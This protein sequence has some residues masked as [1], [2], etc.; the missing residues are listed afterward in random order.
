MLV[1]N[2]VF[3]RELAKIEQA[4]IELKENARVVLQASRETSI[5]LKSKDKNNVEFAIQNWNTIIQKTDNGLRLQFQT[6]D[7]QYKEI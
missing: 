7:E 5:A 3:K 2:T 4:H 1:E 6:V